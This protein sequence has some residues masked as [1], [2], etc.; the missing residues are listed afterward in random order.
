MT[1]VHLL[2]ELLIAVYK[3]GDT[4]MTY[5][6]PFHPP[7]GRKSRRRIHKYFSAAGGSFPG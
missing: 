2:K 3:T 7:V 1:P 4:E 6:C 5:R